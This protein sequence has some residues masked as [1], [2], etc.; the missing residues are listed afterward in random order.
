[1]RQSPRNIPRPWAVPSNLPFD[2]T[3]DDVQ[4]VPRQ[5]LRDALALEQDKGYDITV[6][7]N[8]GR[9]WANVL[10]HVARSARDATPDGPPLFIHESDYFN[11]YLDVT[12]FAPEDAPEFVRIS[13]E[14]GQHTLVEYRTGR[15]VD[16]DDTDAVPQV[17]LAVQTWWP[18]SDGLGDKYAYEDTLSTPQLLVEN[19][20]QTSYRLLDFGDQMLYDE[21]E[22]IRGRPTTGVL[23]A[24]FSVL[25]TGKLEWTRMTVSDDGLLLIRAKAKKLISKTTTAVVNQDGTGGELPQDRADLQDL[26]R[27][28]ETDLRIAYLDWPF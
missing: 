20:Q 19:R 22:G 9:M 28:L 10:L 12:G 26:A 18:D 23:G 21:M 4:A 15:V 24:I 7:T 3:A 2:L 16:L 5:A 1:M 8:G 25:G 14:Y 13:H 6:T 11:A 27:S 17:A